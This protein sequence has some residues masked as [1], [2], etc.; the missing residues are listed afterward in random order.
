MWE[1]YASATQ[2]S[3]WLLCFKVAV[4]FASLF[5]QHYR[6]TK[7]KLA[8]KHFLCP[9]EIIAVLFDLDFI[10]VCRFLTGADME[11]IQGH[12][13]LCVALVVQVPFC[14]IFYF[15][16]QWRSYTMLSLVL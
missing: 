8:D 11:A 6:K 12:W 3:V 13:H 14:F 4:N 16:S 10:Y 1:I 7:P 5:N 15:Q 9:Y 2:E